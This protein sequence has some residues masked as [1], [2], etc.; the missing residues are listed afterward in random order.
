MIIAIDTDLFKAAEINRRCA[1]VLEEIAN[2]VVDN[3]YIALDEAELEREYIEFYLETIK[4]PNAKEHPAIRI[5]DQIFNGQREV[6][7]ITIS[8]HS[9]SHVQKKI[10]EH[11]CIPVEPQLI[12][13]GANSQKVGG[14]LTIL[15]PGPDV[16]AAELRQRSL[17]TPAILREFKNLIAPVKIVYATD[18]VQVVIPF[19][20]KKQEESP[21]HIHSH[22]FELLATLEIQKKY[23]CLNVHL[24]TPHQVHKKAGQVDVYVYERKANP[25]RIWIG[26]CKLSDEGNEYP[27]RHGEI[28]KLRHK[29]K[30]VEE[31]E[32]TNP[33]CVGPPEVIGFMISNA[34][35]MDDDAWQ[36]AKEDGISFLRARLP[37]RW[38]HKEEWLISKLETVPN[39][40]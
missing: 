33:D 39:P 19:P 31:F 12:G 15:L 9:P 8:S 21:S 24:Q 32:K 5:L 27:I 25:R 29:L 3:Y 38:A 17:Y 4:Y 30:A 18:L 10:D 26:E 14:D 40:K 6:V 34:K 11:K 2:N 16:T 1:E 28:A 22:K 35:N 7:S 23:N 37:K 20:D 13:I 36:V